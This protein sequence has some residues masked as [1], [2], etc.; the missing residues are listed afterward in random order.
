M[1][2]DLAITSA[3]GAVKLV[4]VAL[5]TVTWNKN[6]C[7]RLAE[8]WERLQISLTNAQGNR[9]N[10]GPSHVKSLQAI[11][12]LGLQTI[13]FIAQYKNKSF[14]KRV[15]SHSSDK[16]QIE[17]F[18]QR[19]GTLMQEMQLGISIDMGAFVRNIGRDHVADVTEIQQLLTGQAKLVDGQEAILQKLD[20]FLSG[21]EKI[22]HGQDEIQR[23]L[24][25]ISSQI[26]HIRHHHQ[27]APS[28][29]TGAQAEMLRKLDDLLHVATTSPTQP[30]GQ[31]EILDKLERIIH[32]QQNQPLA[33]QQQ[34]GEMKILAMQNEILQKM[35]ALSL[36]GASP[37][38][39]AAVFNELAA[40][41]GPL[42]PGAN[43]NPTVISAGKPM[44]STSRLA[45][46]KI[47]ICGD[48]GISGEFK[49]DD[50]A[51]CA[52]A[53][54]WQGCCTCRRD[55][56]GWRHFDTVGCWNCRNR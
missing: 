26:S 51:K 55:R 56:R 54:P 47:W 18:G 36:Q 23:R 37:N 16:E 38:H 52:S 12:A 11:E 5:Q 42:A 10:L 8:Q 48:C 22:V 6:K 29:D 40:P 7:S 1:S 27:P 24:S 17:D 14:L 21:Q 45:S 20:S 28:I 53:N 9:S 31:A 4:I 39:N 13:D 33:W 46:A 2:A 34:R 44:P 41:G 3:V 25:Q 49:T 43:H 32:L 19:L 35:D 50:P 30:G 15:W